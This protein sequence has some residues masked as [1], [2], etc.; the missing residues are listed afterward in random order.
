MTGSCARGIC[1]EFLQIPLHLHPTWTKT[2]HQLRRW[3]LVDNARV[4][5]RVVKAKPQWR[6]CWVKTG[7]RTTSILSVWKS[8]WFNKTWWIYGEY[9]EKMAYKSPLTW[10][11]ILEQWRIEV[12]SCLSWSR[13]GD[14]DLQDGLLAFKHVGHHQLPRNKMHL[15]IDDNWIQFCS[16]WSWIF[17]R[18]MYTHY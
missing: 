12:G 1:V 15:P 6:T 10:S 5:S 7:K 16:F 9:H 13:S 11:S 14:M 3:P 4:F 17:Y 8:S 18:W 2:T